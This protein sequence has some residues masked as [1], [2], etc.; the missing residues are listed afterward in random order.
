MSDPR[1]TVVD[2]DDPESIRTAATTMATKYSA[3]ETTMETMSNTWS[4]L[5]TSY[6]G[7]DEQTVHQAMQSPQELAADLVTAADAAKK[8]LTSYA[9]DLETLASTRS[10]LVSDIDTFLS[11]AE[12]TYAD[13]PSGKEE[14]ISE[15]QSRC[16]AL[17]EAKDTA[18]NTC[19]ASLGAISAPDDPVRGLTYPLHLNGAREVREVAGWSSTPATFLDAFG[20]TPSDDVH[21]ALAWSLW[22][23]NHAVT[24]VSTY[25]TIAQ[26]RAGRFAPRQNWMPRMGQWSSKT[27]PGAG[28][29]KRVFG[30][31]AR[32]VTHGGRY[33]KASLPGSTVLG[34]M[35]ARS[36]PGNYQAKPHQAGRYALWG[37]VGRVAGPVGAIISGIGSGADQW[38]QD[39]Q[40]HPEMRTAERVGRTGAVG[41]TVGGGAL[42]GAALG[43]SIGSV[44]PGVGTV[45]GGIAGGII[46]G[47]AGSEAGKWLGDKIKEPIGKATQAVTDAVADGGKKVWKKLFG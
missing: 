16:R 14:A 34:R 12:T 36:H 23:V 17:A 32:A 40:N 28:I 6:H 10:T 7:A 39:Q 1:F 9:D 18:Q 8:A 31:D 44:V 4:N 13:D 37:R 29:V 30:W 25:A 38:S 24:G 2:L 5:Q 27:G 22:G 11:T 15:L 33:V 45:I 19:T 21:P 20:V 43:A 3:V 35:A 46:G 42:A 26:H 41:V 47:V